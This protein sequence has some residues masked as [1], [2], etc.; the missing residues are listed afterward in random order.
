MIT[1]VIPTLNEVENIKRLLPDIYKHIRER[2]EVLVVDG[3]STDGTREIVDDL[4]KERRDLRLI[5]QEGKGFACAL[6]TG[7][8]SA[9]GDV[10]VTM[11]AENHLPED[12]LKMVDALQR[13][14]ADVVVGS[15][16]LKGANVKQEY[17]RFLPTRIANK[18][19]RAAL[20]LKVKDCSSGF[21]AYRAK[22]VKDI[23]K[24]MRTEFFSVQVEILDRI[25]DAD[26]K[27][28]EVPIHYVKRE[29]GKSKFKLTP[30]VK[31]ATT[32]LKIARD[33]RINE[34]KKKSE[35]IKVG[36]KKKFAKGRS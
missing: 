34:L 18:F 23:L 5:D 19:A 9:S 20:R 21:R 24:N 11:D 32:I 25:R 36:I 35:K 10:I 2:K 8:K 27:M 12:I 17:R 29:E 31:D 1:I 13:E 3:G 22:T 33:D 14:N 6:L 26:G 15:R 28:I 7:I 16:F 30:A 4:T